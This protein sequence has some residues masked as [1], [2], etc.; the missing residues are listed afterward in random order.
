MSCYDC[1]SHDL[2]I[3]ESYTGTWFICCNKCDWVEVYDLY[4]ADNQPEN[5]RD[6]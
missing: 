6:D 4:K 3:E 2:E 5:Y 1:G